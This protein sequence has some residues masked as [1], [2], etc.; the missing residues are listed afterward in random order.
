MMSPARFAE[1]LELLD[2]S[3]RG[4]AR[5]LDRADGTV[6]QWRN[7]RARVPEAVSDWLETLVAFHAKHPAPLLGERLRPG[8]APNRR[9]AQRVAA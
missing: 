7:G 1:I 9:K 8:P 3:E 6:R 4:L 2:W 5:R